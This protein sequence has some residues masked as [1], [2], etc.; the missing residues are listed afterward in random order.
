MDPEGIDRDQDLEYFIKM[1]LEFNPRANS[2][3]KKSK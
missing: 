1:A 2:S 3:R